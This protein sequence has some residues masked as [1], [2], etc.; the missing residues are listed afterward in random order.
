MGTFETSASGWAVL[1][2]ASVLLGTSK[3]GLSGVGILAVALFALVIP[4]R[5]STG[6]VL[7]LLVVGDA[8]AVVVYRRHAVWSHLVKL[9]PIT[10]VGVIV[11]AL[12]MRTSLLQSNQSVKIVIGAIVI[13]VVLYTY[14]Q[15][16]WKRELAVQAHATWSVVL[17]TGITAG[18]LTMVANAAG[19]IMVFY[20]L[21]IG[22]PKNEFIGTG[23]WFY[24]L[25]NL[26]K[27]PFSASLGLISPASLGLDLILAPAVIA[28]ALMGKWLVSLINQRVFVELTLA[29]TLLSGLDLLLEPLLRR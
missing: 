9:L 19:P 22:L 15:R 20:L 17:L 23:A 12:L 2:V 24:F 16:L 7:P 28:G 18:M 6:I 25:V 13:A 21:A 8:I 29:L 26:F 14:A 5:A 3:T 4:A 10:A 1:V 11:G 27:T